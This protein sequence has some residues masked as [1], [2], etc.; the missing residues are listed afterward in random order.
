MAIHGRARSIDLGRNKSSKSHDDNNGSNDD[1]DDNDNDNDN[2]ND[3][4]SFESV[5]DALR[6]GEPALFPTDT[7][8]GLGVAVEA[9]E[10]PVELYNLKQRSDGKPIAWLVGSPQDLELYGKN[11]PA[12][13]KDLAVHH[14]P[15]ALTLI[16]EASDEVPAAYRASNGTIA[17]RMPD[18]D[19]TLQ[20][21]KAVGPLA[22]TSANLSGQPTPASL[23][24]V[25]AALKSTLP[26][27]LGQTRSGIAST[28]VDCTG[29]TP[30]V[31]RQG[32][33]EL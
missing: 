20:L 13:A 4:R 2:S 7:V 6:R 15:G 22:A 24:E 27:I 8:Y 5:V 9:A 33:I 12:W 19:Q 3:A 25:P 26:A 16:V 18:H 10:S 30:N 21:I 28:V 14:W 23:D 11:I 29:P 32:S 1:I 31:I 17:L